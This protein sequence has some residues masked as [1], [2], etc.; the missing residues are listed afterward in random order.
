MAWKSSS[1]QRD[2]RTGAFVSTGPVRNATQNH[3]PE[4]DRVVEAARQ[5]SRDRNITL[6]QITDPKLR[7][8]AAK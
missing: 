1:F 2:A 3:K 4:M 8:S 7:K 6:E 5:L